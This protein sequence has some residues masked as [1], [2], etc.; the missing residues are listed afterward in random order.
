VEKLTVYRDRCRHF[1][2]IQHDTCDAG[3]SYDAVRAKEGRPYAMFPCLDTGHGTNGE[4]AQRSFL[5]QSEHAA[6]EADMRA[7]TNKM[8]DDI[9]NG[10]CHHCGAPAEPSKVV[11]RCRYNACGHRRGTEGGGAGVDE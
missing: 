5:T 6:E 1:T 9:A 7:A 8:L 4:C 10:R 2:G 11:G 3:V